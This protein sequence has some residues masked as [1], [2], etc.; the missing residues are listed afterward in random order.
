MRKVIWSHKREKWERGQLKLLEVRAVW[1]NGRQEVFFEQESGRSAMDDVIWSAVE[2]T[3]DEF[4]IE[5]A[6]L[7][8]AKADTLVEPEGD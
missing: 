2:E 7:M 3:P 4:L 6:K 5:A 1:D 8:I